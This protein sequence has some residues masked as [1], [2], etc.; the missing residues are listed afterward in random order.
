MKICDVG[1]INIRTDLHLREIV[2]HNAIRS[3]V[4]LS[5]DHIDGSHRTIHG[6]NDLSV[7]Q[8]L[9]QL[10]NFRFT[11]QK[12]RLMGQIL[13]SNRIA[14]CLFCRNDRADSLTNPHS[15]LLQLADA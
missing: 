9:L 4:R 10:G 7:F 12:I 15:Q 5:C 8:L 2:Q 11:G 1:L 6:C 3:A 13:G 14:C